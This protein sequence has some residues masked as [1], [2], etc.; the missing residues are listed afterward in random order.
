MRVKLRK[1]S[2][3]YSTYLAHSYELSHFMPWIGQAAVAGASR[4][5]VWVTE[6]SNP[7][8]QEWVLP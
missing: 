6:R 5:G 2:C 8:R 4:S 3:P 1:P 7:Q